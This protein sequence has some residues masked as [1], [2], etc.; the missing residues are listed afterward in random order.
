[1]N[2]LLTS[3]GRRTY[4]VK[5]FKE[6]LGDSGLVHVANSSALSPAFSAA[7]RTVVTP[8]IY[9][10]QYIPFLLDYCRREHI[11]VL[12][13]LFDIDLP[14]LA[15]A[16]SEFEAARVRVILSDPEVI[17]VCN[18][19]LLMSIFL[20]ERKLATP[21]CFLS[22]EEALEAVDQGELCYPVMIKPRWGMGSLSIYTADN[23]QELEVFYE[24]SRKEI[25]SSYLKYES[26]ADIHHA[27]LIQQALTGQE[28]GLDII[29]DLDKRYRTTIV[30]EKLA[31]R[32]GETD[33]ARV[34][35]MPELQKLGRK[36]SEELQHIGNLDMDII[37]FHGEPYIIDMNARFGG[38]YPYSHMAGVNLPRAIIKWAQKEE[39]APEDLTAKTGQI[40]CKDIVMAEIRRDN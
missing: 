29:N 24:K 27:L 37:M 26:H 16:K 14:V 6:V 12:L 11:Q 18:D 20:K 21:D 38:G 30:K 31:M 10:K 13:S 22:V 33:C 7:D 39:A 4:L 34:V 1:M 3:A 9:D 35:D 25:E 28:Y 15:Q 8:L 2:I 23:Q 5:Y 36:V 17:E 19:K 40:F 32:S